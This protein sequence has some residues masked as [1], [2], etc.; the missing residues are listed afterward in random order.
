MVTIEV[1]FQQNAIQLLSAV[2]VPI[3]S[4][5]YLVPVPRN[6]YMLSDA[7]LDPLYA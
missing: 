4:P 1:I 3:E 2:L 6:I 5:V 7:A